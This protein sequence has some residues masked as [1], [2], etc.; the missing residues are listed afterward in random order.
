MIAQKRPQLVLGF[1]LGLALT[2]PIRR[3]PSAL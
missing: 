1:R 2:V 3:L